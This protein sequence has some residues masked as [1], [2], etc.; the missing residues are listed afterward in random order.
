MGTAARFRFLSAAAEL[1]HEECGCEGAG[2]EGRWGAGQAT[3]AGHCLLTQV[4]LTR[5]PEAGAAT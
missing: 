1:M 4:L 5:L 2:Q 3:W